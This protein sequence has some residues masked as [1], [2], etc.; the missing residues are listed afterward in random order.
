MPGITYKILSVGSIVS[1][2]YF[3][4]ADVTDGGSELTTG[5]L[6]D[7]SV[8]G[9]PFRVPATFV[10][11]PEGLEG[12]IKFYFDLS[13][14]TDHNRNHF[15]DAKEGVLWTEELSELITIKSNKHKY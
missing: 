9:M 3:I 13:A 8:N 11:L 4:N 1:D 14:C 15:M 2:I 6:R 10:R 5:T 7:I 12:H